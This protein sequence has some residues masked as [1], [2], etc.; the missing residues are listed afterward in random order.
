[1]FEIVDVRRTDDG[2]TP[3]PCVSY[4]LTGEP[5]GEL[6]TFNKE[7]YEPEPVYI[8]ADDIDFE[9]IVALGCYEHIQSS[10]FSEYRKESPSSI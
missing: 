6:K 10:I 5:S 1:M 9:P 2:R 7:G 3:D 4:K 8:P